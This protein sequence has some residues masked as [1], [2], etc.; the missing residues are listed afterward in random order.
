MPSSITNVE[1]FPLPI[2]DL[3]AGYPVTVAGKY[4]GSFPT[5]LNIRGKEW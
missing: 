1:I 4:S 5:I 3:Y 2:P